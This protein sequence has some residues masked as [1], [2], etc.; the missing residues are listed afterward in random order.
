MRTT[1]RKRIAAIGLALAL[2]GGGGAAWAQVSDDA[3]GPSEAAPTV[4]PLLFADGGA[5]RTF[6]PVTPCR[7]V[8]TREAVGDFVPNETR[9]FDV[10]G[11]GGTFAAQGGKAGGCGIPTSG[12]GAVEVTVTSVS[13]SSEGFIRVYPHGL[14]NATFLNYTNVFNAGNTGTVS[15]CGFDGSICIVNSDIG[16]TNFTSTTDVVI[17]VFGYYTNAM[18][19]NISASG[20]VIEGSRVTSATQLFPGQYEV[21]FNRD[22]SNC[23]YNATLDNN[24][25]TGEIV[26][27]PR[28]GNA[29]AVFVQTHNSAGADAARSFYLEVIC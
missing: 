28:S 26:V 15:L 7:L 25:G 10:K 5:E 18:A 29:N 16:V 14:P 19:A 9:R 6:V 24:S 27:D 4:A 8:D 3:N 20:T 21:A 22:V 17:D 23:A 2:A 1:R 12:V 11:G 13:A